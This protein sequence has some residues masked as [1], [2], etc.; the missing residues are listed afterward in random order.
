MEDGK[1]DRTG[2]VYQG[3][4]TVYAG[5]HQLWQLKSVVIILGV[6]LYIA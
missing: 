6:R 3:V 4:V 5:T 1:D 2:R